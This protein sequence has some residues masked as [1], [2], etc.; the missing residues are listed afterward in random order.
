MMISDADI[1][2][3]LNY[4]IYSAVANGCFLTAVSG[5]LLTGLLLSLDFSMFQIGLVSAIALLVPLFQVSGA[6]IQQRFFPRKKFW[7]TTGSVYYCCY[8][9][10]AII[11]FFHD[12]VPSSVSLSLFLVVLGLAQLAGHLPAAVVTAWIGD[13]TPET[14][15]NSY[16][17]CR[18]AWLQVTTI[19]A[20]IGAGLAA[21]VMGRG[22]STT[23]AI[24]ILTGLLFGCLSLFLQAKVPD[25]RPAKISRRSPLARLRRLR[26]NEDF[27]VILKFFAVQSFAICIVGAFFFVFLQRNMKF[28]LTQIQLLV[29]I[30]G[31]VGFLCSMWFRRLGQKHGRKKLLL[32]CSLCK[33]VELLLWSLLLPVGGWLMALPCFVL[34]GAVNT[35]IAAIQF[36]LI[37]TVVKSENRS[38]AVAV[39]SALIGLCGFVSAGISGKIY[40]YLQTVWPSNWILAPFNLLCVLSA[41]GYFA[42]LFL[43]KGLK[44]ET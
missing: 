42:G 40:E 28:T 5:S 43:L 12:D 35:G 26:R 41:A 33:A 7:L 29:A 38:F 13:L 32:Y 27:Y 17:N 3:G 31:S 34:G 36:S 20:S 6:L 19:I 23:Y 9:M 44:D 8:L 25:P 14:E 30:S 21:D 24:L 39:F 18:M 11:V 16:W 2:R 22:N 37:S 15:S 4:S 10:L 1:R